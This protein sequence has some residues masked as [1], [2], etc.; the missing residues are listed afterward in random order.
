M[1]TKDVLMDI[2]AR[3]HRSL[4]KILDHCDQFNSGELSREFE[5]F[6]YPT[7]PAT[8]HHTIGA[9]KYWVGVIQGRIDVDD[10]ESE[11]QTI[12]SLRAYRREVFEASQAYLRGAAADEL[13][14]PRPMK[15]WGGNE[16]TLTPATVFLRPAT[17]IYTHLGQILVMSRLMGR[18]APGM[19]FPIVD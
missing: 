11:Y 3:A 9:E 8:F 16:R 18:P 1:Y 13:N 2:H 12:A 4:E 7:I 17:H 5:G 19:D 14:T 10:N 15:T 6:G